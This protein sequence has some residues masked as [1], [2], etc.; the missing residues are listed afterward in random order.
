MKLK[1]I[2]RKKLGN[3]DLHMR[4]KNACIKSLN[5]FL[6]TMVRQQQM[7]GPAP[8]CKVFPKHLINRKGIE[9]Y[10]PVEETNAIFERLKVIDIDCAEFFWVLCHTGL[11]LN[12]GVGLALSHIFK[13]EPKEPNLKKCSSDLR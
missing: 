10:L 4:L 9:S 6:D 1:L 5:R 7:K 8:R 13:G 2:K 12:E 3:L 11:R